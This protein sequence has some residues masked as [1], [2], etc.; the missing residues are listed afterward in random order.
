M[1]WVGRVVASSGGHASEGCVRSFVLI[2]LLPLLLAAGAAACL[3]W[4]RERPLSPEAQLYVDTALALMR[5]HVLASETIDWE[6]LRTETIKRASGARTPN[7]THDAIMWMVKRVNPHSSLILPQFWAELQQSIERNP[8]M[9]YGRMMPWSIGYI[10]LPGFFSS[11]PQLIARYA[12]TGHFIFKSYADSAY[13]GWILDLRADNGGDLNPMLASVGPLLGDGAVGFKR[14]GVGL[15]TAFGYTQGR[16]WIDTDTVLRLPQ[17]ELAP[18]INTPVAVLLGPITASAGEAVAIAFKG[19]PRATS[20][21]ATTAGFT[22]G[23]QGYRLSDGAFVIVTET[24]LGDRNAREYGGVLKPEHPT[25]GSWLNQ[26]AD[27]WDFVTTPAALRW[28]RQQPACVAKLGPLQQ[29]VRPPEPRDDD[30]GR[31]PTT[32]PGRGTSPF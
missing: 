16:V 31:R 22:T 10:A 23:N 32:Q 21:G 25:G 14:T 27:A 6:T 5:H 7:D 3:P 20:F 12:L 2:R 11:D 8:P 18:P 13:C 30:S 24:V 19:V 26:A 4:H 29:Q 1:G 28:L 17:A 9:P 15:I